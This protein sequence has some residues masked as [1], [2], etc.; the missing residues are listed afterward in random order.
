[1]HL[2]ELSLLQFK[3]YH[4]AKFDLDADVNCFVGPNGSGKTNVLDAIYYLS[5]CKS[6]LNPIDRQNIQ[7]GRDFF[8]LQGQF[9]RAEDFEKI[10]CAVK[11]GQKKKFKKNDKEYEKLAD[12]IGQFP[13]VIISPYDRDLITEGSEHR[14]KF[15]DAI[16]S[17]NDH[18]YLNDLIRYNKVLQQRNAL[19]K[20]FQEMRIFQPESIEVWNIQMVELGTKIFEKR[21]AFLELF[22]PKFNHF[23][24]K[25]SDGAEEVGISYKSQLNEDNFATLLQKHERKDQ[26]ATYSTAGIHKDDLVFQIDDM[27]MK[28]FGSQ[29]QQK[30]YLIALKLAQF[31]FIADHYNAKPILLL[32][33]IFDKL[34]NKRVS[35]LMELVSEDTFGQV[36]VTDTDKDRVVSIFSE[37]N[38]KP[39]IF[40]IKNGA[41]Q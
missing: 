22:I 1:M 25:I 10:Y 5:Y 32:D 27:P 20:Q 11:K 4:E 8:V 16:I 24:Q 9:Q 3:N 41:V 17:Q 21:K 29:G 30:S 15:M 2:K 26:A 23:F 12:H 35:K 13:A 18:L 38:K 37:I 28:K 6:Y 7:K 39:E 14:R 36:F 31:E 19:L 33:D 40:E 34:D